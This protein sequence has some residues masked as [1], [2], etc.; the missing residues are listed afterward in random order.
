MELSIHF[1]YQTDRFSK[2]K[3]SQNVL[4]VT[5]RSIFFGCKEIKYFK[6]E[7]IIRRQSSSEPTLNFSYFNLKLNVVIA[8][9]G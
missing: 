5:K 3:W 9:L 4:S 2:R 1:F 8:Y 6:T 7:L